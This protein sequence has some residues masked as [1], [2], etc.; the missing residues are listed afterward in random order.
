MDE[1]LRRHLIDRYGLLPAAN[2]QQAQ[3]F[4]A[5]LPLDAK[6]RIGVELANLAAAPETRPIDP[7]TV[8][9]EPTQTRDLTARV[10]HVRAESLDEKT[11]SVEAVIASDD[12][13]A[14]WD[15]RRGEVIDEI[16][17]MDGAEL[18]A[19]VPLLDNHY[20]WT[21]DDV[22]G[23]VRAM[24]VAE[25]E[26]T[27]RL[28]FAS[29]DERAERAYQK[30]AQGHVR[31]VSAGYRA[32]E[33]TDI[34]P[35]KSAIVAG[36]SY[37]AGQRTLR[38]T[39]RWALKEA[40]VTPIGADA[41]SK[42]RQETPSS[43][44]REQAMPP[45]LRAYLESIGLRKDATDADAWAFYAKTQG[46]QRTEADQHRGEVQPPADTRTSPP[47]DPPAPP[48]DGQRTDPP[49]DPANTDPQA[50]ARQAVAAERE[51]VRTLR[52]LASDDVP[53]EI[54]QRAV[55]E[56]WDEPRANR[57]FLAAVRERRQPGEGVPDSA[58]AGHS[59][60]HERD[61]NARSLAAALL[62]QGGLDPTRYRSYDTA[63][64][65]AGPAFSAQDA[66]LGGRIRGLSAPDLVRECLR[67]D[68]GRTYRTIDE[69]L[70][71]LR[72]DREM[73][74]AA[75]SGGTLSYVFG[76]NI[77]AKLIE[78]WTLSLDSTAGW[79]DEEDVPNFLQQE[80]I[81]LDGQGRPEQHSAGGTATHTTI[82]DSHETYRAYRFSKQAAVDEM[83]IINDRLGAVMKF[84]VLLGQS[85]RRM[86]PNLVYA[87]LLSNPT[88]VADS[89]AVF[90][91]DHSNLGTAA[92][93]SGAL[94]TA[95][96][97]IAS[98]R[99]ANNEVLDIQGRWLIVPTALQWTAATLL[100]SV[101]MAKTHATKSDPDYM[102]V[103]PVGPLVIKQVIGDN[104]TLVSDD[105]IGATG[106]WNPMT[107]A[108]QTGT[109]TNWFLSAGPF[110]GVR[111]LYRR[112][113]NRQPAVRN[114]TLDKGQWGIGWDMNLDIGCKILDF[115]GLYKSTGAV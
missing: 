30:V 99:D 110:R 57:E 44:A 79:C 16:L 6:G 60:S 54:L 106:C 5:A 32:N 113:T 76:T 35:G 63:Q 69:A 25:H 45:K 17:R 47:A 67:H 20:R 82:S 114:Y 112:G 14:V 80:E 8:R 103:N 75:V 102:P 73:G 39:T 43:Q 71:R 24:R 101:A 31:D 56:G 34:E 15:Y 115:R 50:V 61:V 22:Y 107:K 62:I 59:R 7:L 12:P 87:T 37:T 9:N 86:R 72:D 74:R 109:A 70:A 51:R 77:Y 55:D 46:P 92:L 3:E 58:P 11:R 4:Y 36:R 93:A 33:Y 81:T 48:T 42:I 13:V 97:A 90:H 111:V 1:S 2:E 88:L 52:T 91:T 29:G 26:I 89:T 38:V 64:Q 53:A 19:Q 96:S 104:L 98:Q 10:F 68:T 49:A 105:R 85:F 66:D 94:A 83:D 18:P 100:N 21:T 108:T 65:T 95:L 23:S 78:G 41:R 27:G 84:P 28:H 40:S